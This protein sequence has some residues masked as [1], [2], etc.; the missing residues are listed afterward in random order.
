MLLILVVVWF[1]TASTA[2]AATVLKYGERPVVGKEYVVNATTFGG[3]PY[4][5]NG[6]GF[7][8]GVDLFALKWG[9]AEL[10]YRGS[11]R[12]GKAMGGLPGGTRILISNPRTKRSVIAVFAD[13]GGGG[14]CR[15]QLDLHI[16]VAQWLQVPSPAAWVGTVRITVLPGRPSR[17]TPATVKAVRNTLGPVAPVTRPTKK[18]PRDRRTCEGISLPTTN[19]AGDGCTSVRQSVG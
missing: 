12:T 8:G 2:A 10:G 19:H 4:D 5:D 7:H 11:G 17:L 18:L 16:G 3:T 6:I 9:V 14:C 1:A 13:V 15:W